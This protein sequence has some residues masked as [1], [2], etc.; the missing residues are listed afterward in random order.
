[1]ITP[2]CAKERVPAIQRFWL[3]LQNEPIW[4]PVEEVIEANRE[5]VEITNEPFGIR[6]EDLLVSAL[7]KP[8][9]QYFYNGERDIV[10]LACILMFGIAR[11]HPFLQGNK[12]TAF[13][14]AD[15]FI[16]ING[17]SLIVEDTEHV[18][19]MIVD[20]ISGALPESDFVQFLRPHVIQLK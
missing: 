11:N 3:I 15:M 7:E 13:I 10:T 6:S 17:Y 4:I 14:S 20:V 16:Q 1:M 9:N 5:E 8:K 2:S 18:G 19:E 12:R